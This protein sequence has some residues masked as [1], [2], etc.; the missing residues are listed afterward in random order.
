MSPVHAHQQQQPAQTYDYAP[1]PQQYVNSDPNFMAHRIYQPVAG[2]A[3]SSADGGAPSRVAQA[4]NVAAY[5]AGQNQKTGGGI[6]S[7]KITTDD[8]ARIVADEKTKRV[9]LPRYPGLERWRLIEK[10]GDGAFSNVYRAVDTEGTAGEVAIKVV[11]KYEMS[12]NQVRLGGQ[13]SAPVLELSLSEL[14]QRLLLLGGST[15]SCRFQEAAQ[16]R[17]GA[18]NIFLIVTF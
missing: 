14:G 12:Q 15:S 17:G 11:R 16:C 5:T 13:A 4:G 9:K 18:H 10:M 7:Q 8:L 1:Q 6:K 2:D 3:V